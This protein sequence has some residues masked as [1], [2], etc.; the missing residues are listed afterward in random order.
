MAYFKEVDINSFEKELRKNGFS[1]LDNPLYD[2]SDERILS[3]YQ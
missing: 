1:N 2:F 3:M